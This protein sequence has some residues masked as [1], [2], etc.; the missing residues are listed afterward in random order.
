MGVNVAMKIPGFKLGRQ[1][2]DGP[3]CKAYNALN[4]SNHKTVNVQ[5]FDPYLATNQ[6]F[7]DQFRE[8]TGKLAGASFGIMTPILQAEISP[9]ACYVVSE[10]F[11][12]PQQLPSKPLNLNRYQ[13]LQFAMQLAETLDQIHKIGLVHGAIEYSALY[14]KTPGQLMLRPVSLQRVIPLLRSSMLESL[15]QTQKIYL[16]P[17]AGEGLTPATD[18]YA[19]GVLLYQLIFDTVLLDTDASRVPAAWSF[20]D[21]HL[22]LSFFFKALL[23]ADASRRVH[24]FDQFRA[25]LQQCGVELPETV[26]NPYKAEE[27]QRYQRDGGEGASSAVAK[28]AVPA[29]GLAVVSVTGALFWSLLREEAQAKPDLPA[30]TVKIVASDPATGKKG[31]VQQLTALAPKGP[32]RTFPN[33]ENLYRQALAQT[34]TSPKAA[35]MTINVVLNQ[36]PDHFAA[37]KL[38]QQIE[39]EL[40]VRSI[41]DTAERQ[42][43]ELKLLQPTGDNAYESYLILAE[44][45]SADDERVRNGFARIAAAYH[46]RAESVFEKDQLDKALEY[47]E[48]GLSVEAEYPPLLELRVSINDRKKSLERELQ[49]AQQERQRRLEQQQQRQQQREVRQSQ[50]Q[51]E[52]QRQAETLMRNLEEQARKAEQQ[53]KQREAEQASRARV[54]ALLMSA[55]GYL[56]NGNLSLDNVFA[57]HRDYEE[58]RKLDSANIEASRLKRDLME[59][60]T[61]LA[62]R[63]NNDELYNVALQALEQGVQL[64]PQ[65]RRRL[66]IRLQL[67]R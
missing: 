35:L 3:Y 23:T 13:V 46:A 53:A 15:D 28:W 42:L 47:V 59:A 4:L 67:S 49:L 48:L 41:I 51:L 61:I 11:P 10:Y 22:D 19:L 14:F 29:A 7:W 12:S 1:F 20:I 44:K 50:H 62:N 56:N 26:P 65:D 45:L 64:D 31:S 34:E 39:Q 37:L 8:I 52:Q 27:V 18:F 43:Q 24:N 17:E 30:D 36:K 6:T 60:Y 40:W 25:A 5:V 9:Q 66:Q 38:K 57:A 32:V 33:L 58:L 55:D 16:A 63:E 21:E 2:A 54:A